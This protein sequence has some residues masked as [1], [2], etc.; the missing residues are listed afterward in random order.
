MRRH[1]LPAVAAVLAFG[2]LAGTPAR[3]GQA[4]A[5]WR[6][7]DL[8]RVPG[9]VDLVERSPSD[10]FV[11][12][13]SRKGTIQRFGLDGRRID[14]VLDIRNLTTTS[15]ERGLLGLAFRRHAS[16]WEAFVNYT[17]TDGD[18]VI[19]RWAVRTDGTFVRQP[20]HKPSIIM[21]V[22]QPYANHNG[23]AVRVGTDNMLYVATGDGGSGG[24]P[25]R[26]ALDTGSL[27]GKILRID[28][29][30]VTDGDGDDY[31]I[32]AG[33]PYSSPARR[34]IW[35]VGLRNPWRF[36]FDD[37]GNLWVADV[38]QNKWEEASLAPA[39]RAYPGGRGTNFGWSAWE[40][41]H[42]FNTDQAAAGSVAPFLEYDHHDGR[43]SIS[44]GAVTTAQN[45]TGRAGRYIYGDYCAGTLVAVRTDGRRV[46]SSETIGKDLG[47]ITAVTATSRAVYVLTLEGRV[48][49]IESR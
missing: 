34:E 23:G 43:C 44:G 27:L 49:R 31:R 21:R 6:L 3:P 30:H 24:D 16:A 15:G 46:L 42:R 1:L 8:A 45:L 47:N 4:A 37:A 2:T 14:Q 13:V 39:S 17:D 33:N 40:G 28:P 41:S 19:A 22:D 35:S 32:P 29:L 11:Y 18:T 38:G 5:S 12:V 48:R 7:V 26:R 10:R 36:T 20:A 9:A 25:E